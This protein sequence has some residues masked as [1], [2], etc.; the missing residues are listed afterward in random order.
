[1]CARYVHVCGCHM[2]QHKCEGQK[3]TIRS[4]FS[5]S[6]ACTF[7]TEP[8]LLAKIIFDE[9]YYFIYSKIFRDWRDGLVIKNSCRGAGVWF[10]VPILGSS[11]L[12][13]ILFLG[14]SIFY[15]SFH[16][17]CTHMYKPTSKHTDKNKI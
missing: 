4:Q 7:T 6:M 2:S 1:M 11:Q 12:P 9:K 8:S 10:L 15:S 13:I 3:T 17:H 16:G 5:P 14:D